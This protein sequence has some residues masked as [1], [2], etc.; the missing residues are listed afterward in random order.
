MAEIKVDRK[1][2]IVIPIETPGGQAWAHSMPISRV[3]FRS[4]YKILSKTFAEV[5][6]EG[7]GP[8]IGPRVA[9]FVLR[10]VADTMGKDYWTLVDRQLLQEIWRLTNVLMPSPTGGWNTVPFAEFQAQKFAGDEVIEEVE[11]ALVYFT[12]ASALHLK[13]ELPMALEG[14][15]SMWSAQITSLSV[16]EYRSSLTTSTTPVPTGAVPIIPTAR[17]S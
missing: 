15:K 7:Y 5:Y 16:T 11:N 1:L 10:D 2:N 12:V 8:V 3:V 17:A 9:M 6:G 14:L 13:S 4:N